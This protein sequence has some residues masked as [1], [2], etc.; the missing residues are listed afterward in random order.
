VE[1]DKGGQKKVSGW[2][3]ISTGFVGVVTNLAGNP[4][5]KS[6]QGIQDNVLP[7]G[8]YPINTYEQEIDIVEIGLR[9]TSVKVDYKLAEDKVDYKLAEDKVHYKTDQAGEPVLDENGKGISF[10]SSDGFDIHIDFTAIWGLWPDQAPNAIRT[11]G[12]LDAVQEKVLIPQMASISR[13]NGSK[14]K[15]DELLVGDKRQEFQEAVVK[16]F[17]K[18]FDEKNITLQRALVRNIYIPQ[19]VRTPIQNAFIADELTLTRNQ[20]QV[21]AREEAKL[22]QAEKMVELQTETVAS[23]TKKLV[24]EVEATGNKKVAEI[25]ANT[26]K[27]IAAVDKQSADVEAQASVVKGQAEAEG[28]KLIAQAQATRFSQAVSAFGTPTAYNNW[29]FATGLPEQINLKLFYAGEGTLWTDSKNLS[30]IVP[31]KEKK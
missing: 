7:P 12:N 15:A 29:I 31:P 18:V 26:E 6:K 30:V 19:Q 8:I 13:N 23:E 1:T 14:C 9:E 21:T 10:P 28:K 4:I 20:E 16:A 27:K 11:L 22:R 5:T 2:V 3:N 25:A 17:H 24:A